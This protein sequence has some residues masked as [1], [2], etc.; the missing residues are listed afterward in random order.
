MSW[1]FALVGDL[2]AVL[3]LVASVLTWW[4]YRAIRRLRR[5]QEALNDL[6]A[7]CVCNAFANQHLPIWKAWSLYTGC[8]FTMAVEREEDG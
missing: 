5:E 7:T 3:A 2:A 4:Q 1:Q 6:L 8:S